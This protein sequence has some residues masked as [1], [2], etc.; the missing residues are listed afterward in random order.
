MYALP[1]Q[2]WPDPLVFL[3]TCLIDILDFAT[4]ASKAVMLMC[5]AYVTNIKGAL[6]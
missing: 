5:M 2:H 1:E 3:M 6:L 4:F